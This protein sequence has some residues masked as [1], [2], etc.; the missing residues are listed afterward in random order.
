MIHYLLIVLFFLCL[1]WVYFK[2]HSLVHPAIVT[3]IVW[4]SMLVA[5]KIFDHGL[6][7]LSKRFY[8]ALALYVFP[9][10]GFSL[11]GSKLKMD[12]RRSTFAEIPRQYVNLMTYIVIVCLIVTIIAYFITV[13]GSFSTLLYDARTNFVEKEQKGVLILS[14]EFYFF[15]KIAGVS[16][17]FFLFYYMYN[18][19]MV[20]LSYILLAGV[21]FYFCL[22]ADKTSFLSFGLGLVCILYLKGISL[23]NI[24][25]AVFLLL[26]LITCLQLL[27]DMQ[28]LDYIGKFFAIYFLSPMTAFDHVL[29]MSSQWVTFFSGENLFGYIAGW[30]NLLPDDFSPQSVN[31]ND[32]WVHVPLPT[33]VFTVMFNP[34][35]DWGYPGIFCFGIVY[36]FVWGILYKLSKLN[37]KFKIFYISSFWMLVLQF[38]ADWLNWSFLL[39]MFILFFVLFNLPRLFKLTK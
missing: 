18:K 17:S 22:R 37:D 24:L 13:G 19:K 30:F 20:R 35:K 6:Y 25:L 10:V 21:L 29:N 8:G 14:R 23:K 36:G 34:Y 31:P 39:Q 32:N 12:V 16:S 9:F 11:L 38:F 27:R 15:E 5:Y 1:I 2:E 7:D 26:G 3:L 28:D 33:N 4:L